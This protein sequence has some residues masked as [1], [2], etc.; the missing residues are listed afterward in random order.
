[1][2]PAKITVEENGSIDFIVSAIQG[3]SLIEDISLLSEIEGL[4]F[5]KS[6]DQTRGNRLVW[7]NVGPIGPTKIRFSANVDNKRQLSFILVDIVKR[8]NNNRGGGC[9]TGNQGTFDPLF[10]IYLFFSFYFLT[11]H[12]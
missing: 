2:N 8:G 6:N 1:L 11:N 9:T 5:I 12:V 3:A 4:S 10:L 7:Q